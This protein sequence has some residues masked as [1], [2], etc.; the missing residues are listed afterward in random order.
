MPR[1]NGL[2]KSQTSGATSGP[3]TP[4]RTTSVKPTEFVIALERGLS[5][6]RSF[7]ADHRRMT[8]AEV[9][10]LTGLSRGTSR[11]FLL[12][13]QTLGYLASDGKKFWPTPQ[14]LHLGYSYM[15][16]FG[17]TDAARDVMQAVSETVQEASSLAV[18]DGDE[19]VFVV[20]VGARRVLGTNIISGTRLPAHCTALGRVLLAGLPDRQLDAVLSRLE[21][22]AFTDRTATS[23]SDL[24]M[25]LAE[26]RRLGYSIDIGEVEI[27]L[28]SIALPVRN[29]A[30][31]VLAAINI[32][33]LSARVS[34][35]RMKGE[36]YPVLRDAAERI[37]QTLSDKALLKGN[38]STSA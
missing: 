5:V 20:R 1:S 3:S 2:A 17:I 22:T 31:R 28:S 32:G 11:R 8:L 13:L 36:F 9:A 21:L 15:A 12:T 38:G 24:K 7:D 10:A 26:V 29:T 4:V 30:H 18:L 19:I 14:V 25:K 6:L 23:L 34:A 33:C 27:G 37:G 16:A 35:E